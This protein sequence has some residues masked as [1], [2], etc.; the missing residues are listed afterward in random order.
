MGAARESRPAP[1]S[2]YRR[3]LSRIQAPAV[4][5]TFG[6]VAPNFASSMLDLG[7]CPP[8][9]YHYGGVN[10]PLQ[11]AETP[12]LQV[13]AQRSGKS[14]HAKLLML[15][16]LQSIKHGFTRR[17]FGFD[18]KG[19]YLA[20]LSALLPRPSV[21]YIEPFSP[22]GVAW[23]IAAEIGSVAE[24]EAMGRLLAPTNPE[25]REPFFDESA[26][27]AIAGL[28][29]SLHVTRGPDWTLL[30]LVKFL[31]GGPSAIRDGLALAPSL[32]R[33]R[34]A[35]YFNDQKMN[36]DVLGT[37]GN[38]TKDLAAAAEQWERAGESITLGRWID[39]EFALFLGY[40]HNHPEATAALSRAAVAK[41]SRLILAE[42]DCYFPKSWLF[43]DELAFYG[44]VDPLP[45]LLSLGPAK[46]MV[47]SMSFQDLGL[48]RKVY[49]ADLTQAINGLT[50]QKIFCRLSDPD[51]AE[52]A[53][54]H[55]G[56]IESTRVTRG[57][58]HASGEHPSTTTSYT[59]HFDRS[60]AVRP[61]D[62]LNIRPLSPPLVNELT[63]Y[64]VSPTLG[65][66][67]H[68]LHLDTIRLLLPRGPELVAPELPK[69]LPGP[70]RPTPPPAEDNDDGLPYWE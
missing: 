13:G 28:L 61:E 11:Y 56:D 16:A 2:A 17:L 30:D 52:W 42:P 51:T 58:S 70:P 50:P 62:F 4:E 3:H 25:G 45:G 53:S 41:L 7:F 65:N 55:F 20:M 6:R 14:T 47:A 43:F 18:F 12:F 22:Y 32:N 37:L 59:E 1:V 40:S 33:G 10:Y 8:G 24:A 67:C 64:V 46:G 57:V 63:S 54:R 9:C 44:R 27:N 66:Y 35:F 26:G 31:N 19:E 49:G 23:D 5:T 69:Q 38:R 68:A 34:I 36:R 29:V 15:S 21:K 60:R 39:G 48:M